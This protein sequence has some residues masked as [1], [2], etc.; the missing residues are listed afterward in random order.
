M[1]S[2]EEPLVTAG[3]RFLQAHPVI[4]WREMIRGISSDNSYSD[5]EQ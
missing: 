4:Q 5:A 2:K 3:A 1:S